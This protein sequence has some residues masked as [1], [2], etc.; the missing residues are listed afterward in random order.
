MDDGR[1]GRSLDY[2]AVKQSRRDEIP[3]NRGN[4]QNLGCM[5]QDQPLRDVT[6]RLELF[7][8][9]VLLRNQS[10]IVTWPKMN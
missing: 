9:G 2:I 4:A 7:E 3:L 6:Q 10:F 8:V 5:F 1:R